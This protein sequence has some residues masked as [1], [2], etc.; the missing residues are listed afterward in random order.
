M[1]IK[2]LVLTL[3]LILS[4]GIFITACGEVNNKQNSNTKKDSKLDNKPIPVPMA[5]VKLRDQYNKEY[6]LGDMKGKTVFLNFFASWCGPCLSEVGDIQ[7]LY[8]KNGKNSKDV[9]VLGI[10]NPST[11]KS[12]TSADASKS[13]IL[14]V[15][16]KHNVNYPI[17]FDETGEIFNAFRI[18][19]YPTTYTFKNDNTI[20]GFVRG[21]MSLDTMQ[22]IIEQTQK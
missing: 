6:T 5:H 17:L 16:Q 2:K 21:P 4:A 13:E 22:S 1:I 7:K 11:G 19:A 3:G 9:L 18:Q 8:E 15:L 14:S 20:L 12:K 10:A